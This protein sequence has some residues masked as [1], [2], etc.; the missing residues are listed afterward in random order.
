LKNDLRSLRDRGEAALKRILLNSDP[1]VKLMAAV[2]LLAVD[3]G[4]AV[5]VLRDLAEHG[6]GFSASDAALTLQEWEA[7]HLREY[8]N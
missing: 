3:E 8:W 4:H 6:G 5:A 7:G 2:A 1:H